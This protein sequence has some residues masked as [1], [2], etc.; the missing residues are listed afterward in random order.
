VV[1]TLV[2]VVTVLLTFARL[3]AVVI[4]RQRGRLLR[5][6]LLERLDPYQRRSIANQ[7]QRWLKEQQG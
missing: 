3:G 1:V 7:A 4:G 5:R 6:S 2:A